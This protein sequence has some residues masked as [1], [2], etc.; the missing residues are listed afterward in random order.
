MMAQVHSG[1]L[2]FAP[3]WLGA[4]SVTC[5]VG[6]APVPVTF[7]R[8]VRPIL[9]ENCYA[10]HGPDKNQRKAKLRLDVREVAVE[11]EA[12]VPGKPEES[13]LVEHIFSSDPDEIMPPLKTGKTLTAAQKETFKNWIAAGAEYEPHWAYIP[14]KRPDVPETQN[15]QWVRTPID[16]FILSSLET[17]GIQPSP[18]A[19]NRTLLRCLSLDLVGLPP[20]PEEIKAFLSE[21]TATPYDR[22]L[23][24]L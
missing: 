12:F 4:A 19:A 20:T 16:A 2:R 24:L 5:V 10:C 18:E 6:A 3:H 21:T 13:K 8:D 17:K 22:H 7:N 1:V 23:S 15:P 14:L 11:R 9:T